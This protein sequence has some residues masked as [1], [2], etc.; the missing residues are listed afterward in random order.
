[1]SDKRRSAALSLPSS[2]IPFPRQTPSDDLRAMYT[3]AR[4]PSPQSSAPVFENAPRRDPFSSRAE[5]NT[6]TAPEE[7]SFS[8]LA[9]IEDSDEDTEDPFK[10]ADISVNF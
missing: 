4:A 6:A 7:G 8:D 5:T 9:D 2:T 3:A 10:D 1:M